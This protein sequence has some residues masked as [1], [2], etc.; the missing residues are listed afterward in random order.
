VKRTPVLVLVPVETAEHCLLSEAL[1]YVALGRLPLNCNPI[2]K[3]GANLLGWAEREDFHRQATLAEFAAGFGFPARYSPSGTHVPLFGNYPTAAATETIAGLQLD[4]DTSDEDIIAGR[5]AAQVFFDSYRLHMRN[6]LHEGRLE[7]RGK[8]L[9]KPIALDEAREVDLSFDCEFEPI[10]REFWASA[11]IDWEA[12]CAQG[13]IATYKFV[14]I[15]TNDL[16]KEFPLP[17]PLPAPSEVVQVG[18]NFVWTGSL[19][20]EVPKRFLGRPPF[21]WDEFHLEV[22]KRVKE[23]RLPSKQEA[24]IIDMES[25]CRDRWGQE[26]GRSTLLQKIKP[27]YDTFVRAEKSEKDN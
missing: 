17:T 9:P 14:Q 4:E 12:S 10:S 23:D 25:W 11:H 8:R 18:G 7:G 3:F 15:A 21:K 19:T 16:F 13:R 5:Q 20:T 2:V 22:A 6:L 1:H 24:F 27:Y 26:V